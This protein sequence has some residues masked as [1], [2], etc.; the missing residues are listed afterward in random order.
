[1][2]I[3]ENIRMAVGSLRAGKMRALLTMLG[4]II[5]IGSVI[6]IMTVSSSL[7]TSIAD[8]FQEMG[9][10]NITVGV[11]QSSEQ[12]QVSANGMRFGTS[13]KSADLEEDD[14]ITDEMIEG[15]QKQYSDQIDAIALSESVGSGTAERE[16]ESANITIT[17]INEQ[18][19]ASSKITLLAGRKIKKKDLTGKKK[20]I[21]VTDKVVE[22]LF[23][24]DNSA[25]LAQ[26][27]S[28]NLDGSYEKYYIVGVY[29]Y[30]SGSNV[31]ESS[32]EDVTTAAYIPLTTAKEQTHAD[33]GYSQFTVVTSTKV[34]S[35]SAF[36]EQIEQYFKPYYAANEDYEVS[37]STMESMTESM[38][39]M[40]QTVSIAIAFIAG[41]SLLVGGIGVMNIMLVSVTER[42]REIGTRKALGAKNSSIRLQ[43][44]IESVLLCLVGGILGIVVGLI[45][46]AAAAAILGY[47]ATAPVA[48]MIISVAFSMVIGIFFGYY[49]AG[50]AAK[51]DPIEALRYE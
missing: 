32:D 18:Y 10:N 41:I 11:K 8:S 3:I 46:G 35:V 34:D 20:V 15:L 27:I 45:L 31:S 43:F 1:M 30:E 23:D 36:A 49:P 16:S 42:T 44:I 48:A 47:S 29:K 22:N 50:K 17:G 24:G 2:L 37:T 4:I 9:A 21:M 39:E 12:E 28:L 38:T 19:F 14:R 25:A 6:A 40:V 5:G 51:L 13:G 26:S 33:E 7:T